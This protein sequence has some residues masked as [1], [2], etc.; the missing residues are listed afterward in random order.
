MDMP[1]LPAI[2]EPAITPVPDKVELSSIKSEISS[3]IAT[4]KKE[5]PV[6]VN[7]SGCID[8]LILYL[9]IKTIVETG[10]M[11]Y[12]RNGVY[13]PYAEELVGELL[14]SSFHGITNN[15]D[16]PILNQQT[17]REILAQ[18]RD[19]TYV[20]MEKF[21]NNLNIINLS[22]G[23]YNWR[24]DE[25]RP[26]DHNYLS[27][28]QVPVEY[29]P[30]AKCPNVLE[31]FHVI[32]KPDDI[33]KITEFL[34]Y[35]LYR[36][37]PGRKAFILFGNSGTGKSIFIDTCRAFVGK[38]NASSVAL[39]ELV[40]DRFAGS[41]LFHKLLN[42][43]GDI[44]A[45]PITDT[46][47]IK[48]LTGN[49]D[50]VR[51]Q[52]KNKNAF[53][54]VNYAKL[55]FS[56]NKLPKVEDKNSGWY[57]RIELIPMDHVLRSN[58]FSPEFLASLTSPEELSGLFNLAMTSL[59]KLASNSWVFTNQTDL[60]TTTG[61][62]DIISSPVEAFA[63]SYLEESPEIWV[64]R[65]EVFEAFKGFCRKN[66][67]DPMSQTRFSQE[68]RKYAPWLKDAKSC[69]NRK[70]DGRSVLIWP[71]TKLKP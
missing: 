61:K 59:R 62:Y 41:D 25:F 2:L 48:Q 52:K 13:L 16:S 17:K 9:N 69:D 12:Y 68:L 36:A 66:S 34:G 47:I 49:K 44:P 65:S 37:Y 30:D 58:E 46:A 64:A 1:L 7:V 22:N 29:N 39:Q 8:N 23:L 31:C 10:E 14:T 20:H 19:L 35:L 18:L 55:L 50:E 15:N 38:E 26:H 4:D 45:R 40:N 28:I 27:R 5:N 24:S 60:E 6:R 63:E 53:S 70:I 54:F 57:N 42:E 67:I 33:Q 71:H 51:A 43:C 21:D 11:L 32:F 56:A 3:C